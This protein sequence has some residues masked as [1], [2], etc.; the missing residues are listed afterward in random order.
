VT[1]FLEFAIL[2]LGTGAIYALITQGLIVIYRGS[3]V[4][5][6]AQSTFVMAGAF[7]FYEV[8]SHGGSLLFSILA[9]VAMGALL[10]ATVQAGV[11]WPLRHAAP[12][13]KVIG[14]LAVF[15]VLVALADLIYSNTYA[16]VHQ[17]LPTQTW[18]VDGLV[19]YL[20]QLILLGI[21]IVIAIVLSIVR[22]RTLIGLAFSASSENERTA[23]S[24]GW[25]PY[26]IAMTSWIAGGA[27]AGLAGALVAPL[28]GLDIDTLSLLVIPA[29]AAALMGRF[30]SFWRSLATAVVVGMFQSLCLFY[31]KQT[32]VQDAVPF[33]I[34]IIVLAITGTSIPLRSHIGDRLPKIGDGRVRLIPLLGL[35]VLIGVLITS[36][37]STVW[38]D[39]FSIS[40]S[41][42]IIL[43]S[44]VVLTGYAGQITLAQFALA[45]LGAFVAGRLVSSSGWP[46]WAALIAGVVAA[47]PIGMLFALPALR[48][49]GINLAIVTLGLAAVVERM[50]F[51]SSNYTGGFFGTNV[52]DP[53]LFGVNISAITSPDRYGIFTLAALILVIL[54]VGNLRR[55]ILGRQLVAIRA[56]ERAAASLGISIV[57]AKMYAFAIGSAIAAL[58]GIILAF[59]NTSIIYSEFSTLQSVFL[60]AYAMIGGVGFIMGALVG[61]LFATGGIGTLINPLLN[62]IAN[63]LPL[64]SGL[65]VISVLILNPNGIVSKFIDDKDHLKD[66]LRRRSVKR[67]TQSDPPKRSWLTRR[68]LQP[69]NVGEIS[70]SDSRFVRV[71]EKR[72]DIKNVCIRYGVVAAVDNFSLTINS[73]EVVGLIGPNGAGKTSLIDAISGFTRPSEGSIQLDGKDIT[74]WSAHRRAR[75]GLTR[76]WQSL[77][78]F[79]DVSVFENLLIASDERKWTKYL[80]GLVHPGKPTL[81]PAEMAVVKSFHLASDLAS[82]PEELSYGKRRLLAVARAVA[83][84]PSILLLDEPAAGLGEMES[85]ELAS[86][87]RELA[88][89]W[90]FGILLVE[91]D[92]DFVMSTC[93]RIAVMDFGV[94]IAEGTPETVRNDQSV[95]AA[96][97]G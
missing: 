75:A 13:T 87:V 14:T 67:S 25:S 95:I 11:M 85:S 64:I 51:D 96:Y 62:S 43:L 49:R 80:T 90:G 46:F 48:T 33:I 54:V 63:Y 50:V 94:K 36:V 21:A 12:M 68:L 28:T 35:A 97:L 47:V 22:E 18:K 77:E 91:H 20:D 81:G 93:D 32:G 2:G 24:L 29:L 10:G 44:I 55:S 76:S 1:D 15:I 41:I 79:E 9:A 70:G 23:A 56:N 52:G 19:I 42:A 69:P 38:I 45:G 3:G 53:S 37:F 73:G 58:G 86:L 7:A 31:V 83:L 61:S 66:R 8:Q 72:I 88:S 74:N 78:L 59:R 30:Q 71:S 89:D 5:N 17:Y 39:A 27:L 60:V 65:G 16:T 57:S 26:G 6:F 4:V 82:K 84:S 40:F 34:I 92:I